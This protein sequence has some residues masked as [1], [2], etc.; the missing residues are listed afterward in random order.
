MAEILSG[1]GG[2]SLCSCCGKTLK[3][4]ERT[5]PG[6]RS[7]LEAPIEFK[8][9]SKFKGINNFSKRVF[10]KLTGIHPEWENYIKVE[11]YPKRYKPYEL[12]DAYISFEI[13][14]PVEGI[15]P[16]E[17]TT[18]EDVEGEI[19]VYFGPAHFHLFMYKPFTVRNL[20]DQIR[21]AEEI[22]NKI[23]HEELIAVQ[24]KPG[25]F[26]F[27]AEGMIS[28]DRYK[29]LLYKGKIRKAVSWKGTFNYPDDGTHTEW[30]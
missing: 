29:K 15:F 20:D 30:Y 11:N 21:A 2:E 14:S 28:P 23:I 24:K 25:F 7:I 22:V 13:P 26:G 10:L 19:T 3:T 6:C 16:I 5:C 1:E 12:I 17:I 4:N 8:T 27:V 18:I 9:G